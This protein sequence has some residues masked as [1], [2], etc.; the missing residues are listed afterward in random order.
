MARGINKVILVGHLGR[1]PDMRVA[2]DGTAR[3]TLSLAVNRAGRD[4]AGARTRETD[5]FT[6]IFWASAAEALQK[7]AAT[8]AKLFVEGA[9]R[10]R[11]YRDREGNERTAVE[12]VG[13]EFIILVDGRET[14]AQAAAGPATAPPETGDDLADLDEL[15]S[16]LACPAN[17]RLTTWRSWRRGGGPDG[18]ARP[19][20]DRAPGCHPR[21]HTLMGVCVCQ[22]RGAAP[23]PP[24][25]GRGWP[26]PA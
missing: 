25:V 21:R 8:G 26:R 17:G 4:S 5:W 2:A 7:Y 3:A 13:R 11:T 15:P 19:P 14:P 23:R 9:L 24:P 22:R 10:V 12:I 18:P 1:K 6:V 20:A 16:Y